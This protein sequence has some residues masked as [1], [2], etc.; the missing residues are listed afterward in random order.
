MDNAQKAIMIGVGLFIT[1]I[2][3]AAVMLITG[4]GQDLLNSGQQQVTNISSN[5]QT[6]L[7]DE[8][9][10]TTMTGAKVIAAVKR[11]RTDPGMVI[12]VW[13]KNGGSNYGTVT[14]KNKAHVNGAGTTALTVADYAGTNTATEPYA[15]GVSA[16]SIGKLSDTTRNETYVSSTSTYKAHLVKVNG[17]VAGIYFEQQ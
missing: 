3:I 17:G 11:Y 9:D 12:Y 14:I 16:T 1:I 13:N 7:T 4:M 5:L 2:I 15:P 8:F 6:Q 10:E